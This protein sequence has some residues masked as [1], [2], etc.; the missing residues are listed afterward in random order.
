VTHLD[1]PLTGEKLWSAMQHG[2]MEEGTKR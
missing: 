1:M 2:M